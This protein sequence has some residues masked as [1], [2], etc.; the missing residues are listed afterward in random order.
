MSYRS[1]K[2]VLGETSL[3]RKCRFLFGACL[4]L[5]ITG[6][7]WWY[8]DQTE[9]IVNEQYQNTGHL[10]VDQDMQVRHCN[11][12]GTKR[13]VR[14]TDGTILGRRSASQS[15]KVQ[16]HPS[17]SAR[18][19]GRRARRIQPRETISNCRPSRR[20]PNDGPGKAKA[21]RR[22][23]VR[24]ADIG[25]WERVLLLPTDPR[26]RSQMFRGLPSAVGQRHRRRLHRGAG[27]GQFGGRS[28]GR[29]D[30]RRQVDVL[31]QGHASQHHQEPRHPH[32]HGHHHRVPG[33]GGLV[34]HRPL[35][36]RQAAA[37]PAR[38]ERRRS[39]A[40][41]PRCGPTSTPATSSRSWPWPST[42][43]CGT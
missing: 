37:A 43:C 41:T 16:L 4:L 21:A 5:L 24:R 7:F 19:Q 11:V 39:A 38:R 28:R 25:G 13:E 29:P 32:R 30:G 23:R 3:E 6:S 18:G 12:V 17:E 35:R 22:R 27:A 33:D 8:G 20:F 2:R 34:C 26:H 42:A 9:E 36:D 10:L 40:A 15:C 31:H 1:I 14:R